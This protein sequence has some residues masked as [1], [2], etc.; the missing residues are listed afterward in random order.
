MY[1]LINGS[2]KVR[3]SN[4]GVFLTKLKANL[5]EYNVFELKKSKKEDILNS[6]NDSE[7]IV[8]AFPLYVDSPTS[9][10]LEFLDYVIDNK[11]N[12]KDKL[13]YVIINCGFREGIQN[14]TAINIIKNWC[15]RTK[16]K[17]GCSI[18]IGAGEIIGKAKYK[19]ISRNATK[20]LKQFSQIV[21]NKEINEDI[22]TTVDFMD[23]KLFCFLANIS[24]TNDGKKHK[25]TKKNIK[26]Q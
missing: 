15:K 18:L 17:Y 1:T 22:V 10:T 2:P 24:W 26:K 19:Y 13:V 25:L 8:F 12:L 14:K 7:V 4:S 6:I 20:K 9:I 21:K 16:A 23:N 3:D 5:D 11:I